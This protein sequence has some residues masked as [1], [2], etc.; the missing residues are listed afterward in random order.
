MSKKKIFIVV[1]FLIFG[2]TPPRMA[3][4]NEA[5]TKNSLDPIINPLFAVRHF[6][7]VA[8]SPDGARVAWVQEL[9][10][11]DDAPSGNSAIYVADL[12]NLTGSPRRITAGEESAAHDE[13][14]VAWSPDGMRLAF[15][16]DAE[17]GGQLQLYQTNVAAGP[18]QRLT[19]L[20]GF[21]AT[22]RWSPDGKVIA[23]LFTENAPRAAGPL[24]PM[25]PDTGVVE[26][27]I[28]EQ[29]LTTVDVATGNVRQLSPP[30]LYV[31]E[32]DWSPDGKNFVAT[33][34][35][36]SGDDNWYVAELYILSS[37]SGGTKSIFKPSLQVAVP[38]WSPDA[39]EIG[40]IG[41]LMSDEGS[42]GGDVFVIPA[43]GGKPRNLTPGLPASA[44]S[45]WWQPSSKQILITEARDGSPGVANVSLENERVETL[46]TGPETISDDGWGY[47]LSLAADGK[48]SAIVRSSF[49]HPPEVWAGSMGAWKQVTHLNQNSSP[50]WGE[51]KSI[52]WSSDNFRVQ[53]WLLYPRDYDPS[54][55][56]P[57]IVLVHG[58]PGSSFAPGWPRTF[59]NYSALS[60]AGY[61]VLLPNPR[62]SFGEGE[63]FT[64]ANVKDFGYGDLRDILAGVDEVVKTLPVDNNRVGIT[65]WSYGGFMTM[66]AVTQTHRFGAA[67]AGAGLSNWQSYYGENDLDQWMIPFFGAS[68]Y[69]DPAVYAKSS[70]I[71]YIKN[72]RTPTLV[73]VGDRDGEC[74]A[75]QSYEFWHALK[76]LGVKT[77]LV[78]YANEG[79]NI[80]KPEDQ[81]DIIQRMVG[82]F[83]AYLK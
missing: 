5:I 80:A 54:K 25:T 19:N 43:E 73:L 55:R 74:P 2:I 48:T 76:T 45:I 75:P 10:G 42:I 67:V 3:A 36:G 69:D 40:F 64:Q 8:I 34:A 31:Y 23:L 33:A 60:S 22:P 9:I 65:G 58:G 57:M 66:W 24:E 18:T 29:R 51:A 79:H 20:T 39:K 27:H 78:I 17:T 35:H 46:W 11:R 26:G 4:Q 63:T 32:Y 37:N 83:D 81:R 12:K 56:Y 71:N 38:R 49:E 68:V 7:Q 61:F 6:K 30:D 53:G 47:G 15:L 41:G 52:H 28:Y 21:L 77:Q 62:G 13:Q 16:S 72:V 59:L 70:A 14:D 50:S 44:S 82:W 1:V